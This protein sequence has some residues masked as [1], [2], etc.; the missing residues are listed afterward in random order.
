MGLW[1]KEEG[2][3]VER[4][5]SVPDLAGYCGLL[6]KWGAQGSRASFIQACRGLDQE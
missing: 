2:L 1:V 6:R 4:R 3:Q 5:G